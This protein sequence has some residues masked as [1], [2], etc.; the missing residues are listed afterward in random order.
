MCKLVAPNGISASEVGST[1]IKVT[2]TAGSGVGAEGYAARAEPSSS[3]S[4]DSVKSCITNST[5]ASC[6]IDDLEPATEYSVTVFSV[7]QSSDG[8]RIF[9]DASEVIIIVTRE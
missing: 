8:E 1:S 9:G 2:W 6:T 7:R 5:E 3:D 4:T